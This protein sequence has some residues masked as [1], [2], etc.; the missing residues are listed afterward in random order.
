MI[1]NVELTDISGNIVL[2]C[3]LKEAYKGN[4]LMNDHMSGE[5]PVLKPGENAISWSGNVTSV[6]IH[7]DWRWL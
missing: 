5:F 2:D 7:P 3:A 1:R 6:A 4:I